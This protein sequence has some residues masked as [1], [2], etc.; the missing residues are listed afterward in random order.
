MSRNTKRCPICNGAG[1]IYLR[2]F[3]TVGELRFSSGVCREC[4]GMGKVDKDYSQD[5]SKAAR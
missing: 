5:K 1:R 2:N 4:K 3:G